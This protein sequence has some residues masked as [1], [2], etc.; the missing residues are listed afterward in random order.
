MGGAVHW[1]LEVSVNDGQLDTFKA[2]IAEMV[3]AT[4]KEPGTLIYEWYFDEEERNCQINERYIDSAATMTHLTS[5]AGFAERFM[6]AVTPVNFI[7]MGD[8][9]AAV[10]E[11]LAGLNPQY[12]TKEAGLA[13]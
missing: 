6:A 13:R 10:R 4:Q 11:E 9:D 3:E 5:F 2:L 12:L 8:A 1:L 7:V